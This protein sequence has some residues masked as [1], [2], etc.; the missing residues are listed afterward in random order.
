[1]SNIRQVVERMVNLDLGEEL[2]RLVESRKDFRSELQS[3]KEPWDLTF[4]NHPPS[5]T[6][7][8]VIAA[9]YSDWD[10]DMAGNAGPFA[11]RV[12][13]RHRTNSTT[14][15]YEATL[16]DFL[17][18]T[19]SSASDDM[20]VVQSYAK[21]FRQ[22]I[23]DALQRLHDLKRRIWLLQAGQ[24]PQDTSP[25]IPDSVRHPTNMDSP[26]SSTRQ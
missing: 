13:P 12:G 22:E 16:V 3:F 26:Y 7:A 21:E 11:L 6:E 2:T 23:M 8:D 18:T 15:I 24:S 5:S 19:S 4:V 10:I 9:K 1:M 14:I 20:G 17:N 25:I